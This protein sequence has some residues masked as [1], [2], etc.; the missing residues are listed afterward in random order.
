MS[1]KRNH[2]WQDMEK[3][4][5]DLAML[6]KQYEVHKPKKTVLRYNELPGLFYDWLKSRQMST[7]WGSSMRMQSGYSSL[8][9]IP[10]A[11]HMCSG[12]SI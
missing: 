2:R 6:I 9:F 10:L 1:A 4:G 11:R 7:R 5:A 8:T 12:G 3:A